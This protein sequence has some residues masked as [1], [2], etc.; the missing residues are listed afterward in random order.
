M[1][2]STSYCSIHNT[3]GGVAVAGCDAIRDETQNMR[4]WALSEAHNWQRDSKAINDFETTSTWVLSCFVDTNLELF[5]LSCNHIFISNI[6]YTWL[7]PMHPHSP[8]S[9]CWQKYIMLMR[10][11]LSRLES[12]RI[13]TALCKFRSLL[14]RCAVYKPGL[15]R[16][17][18]EIDI[19]EDNSFYPYHSVGN[20]KFFSQLTLKSWSH[21]LCKII[22]TGYYSMLYNWV[23]NCHIF[24]HITLAVKVEF[25]YK[26]LCFIAIL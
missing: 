7:Y 4:K 19:Q 2:P 3:L 22:L 13:S 5:V 26:L 16:M 8:S 12:N 23:F 21:L 14:S 20:N 24:N 11:H 25:W 15:E 10:S 17:L 18:G 1:E 9:F 6:S